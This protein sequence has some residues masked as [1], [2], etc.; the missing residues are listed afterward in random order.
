M[1]AKTNYYYLQIRVYDLQVIFEKP[2]D[3]LLTKFFQQ[4]FSYSPKM[5]NRI[6]VPIK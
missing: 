4:H 3:I 2:V 1:K 5:F 6:I